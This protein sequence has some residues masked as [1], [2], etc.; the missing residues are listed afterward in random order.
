MFLE[1][2]LEPKHLKL[3]RLFKMKVPRN[4]FS[5]ARS[6]LFRI[7]SPITC[8]VLVVLRCCRWAIF[9]SIC[10]VEELRS[11]IVCVKVCIHFITYRYCQHVFLETKRQRNCAP[12]CQHGGWLPIDELGQSSVAFGAFGFRTIW[13]LNAHLGSWWF[14]VVFSFASLSRALRE[15]FA[16]LARSFCLFCRIRSQK[17]LLNAM[18]NLD[19]LIRYV[20]K[21]ETMENLSSLFTHMPLGAVA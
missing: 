16:S 11:Q 7:V 21:P 9:V 12:S 20:Q 13:L 5:A 19:L 2:L 6:R 10:R 4:C 8:L 17:K 3:I 1:T 15:A 18:Q 14:W